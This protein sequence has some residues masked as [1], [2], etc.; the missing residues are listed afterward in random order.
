M[1]NPLVNAYL[2][3]FISAVITYP[4]AVVTVGVDIALDGYAN[5]YLMGTEDGVILTT[6]S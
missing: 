3:H 2:E 4:E 5:G 6:E 1:I